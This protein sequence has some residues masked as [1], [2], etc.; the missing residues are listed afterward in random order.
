MLRIG[1][2]VKRF[3]SILRGNSGEC[4]ICER[5]VRFVRNPGSLRD[6]YRCA[7]CNSIPRLRAIVDAIKRFYPDW[8]NLSIHESSPNKASASRLLRSRCKHYSS[9]QFFVDVPRGDYKDGHR[10]EDLSA[11]TFENDSFDLFI[12]QDVFEH[13]MDAT[14]AF[15]EIARVLKPGGAHIFTMPWYGDLEFSR[16]RA[17]VVDNKL[18][19]LMPPVYHGNP[20]DRKG[21]SL[22][23]IDW[24]R[25]FTDIV[26]AASGLV[27][28]ILLQRDRLKGLDGD[29]LEV[30]IS[31][32]PMK[33]VNQE[34]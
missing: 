1:Q 22:V 31:R 12:T 18:V 4:P 6:N 23:T 13:V 21:G 26:F 28:T 27:T 11:L 29:F 2:K 8:E 16:R 10:S 15:R 5:K 17:A 20:I 33:Q 3:V 24:G 32:K 9:S 14:S 34:I 19:N 7:S 30:F 25:D